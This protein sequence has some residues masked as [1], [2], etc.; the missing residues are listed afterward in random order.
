MQFSTICFSRLGFSKTN[1]FVFFPSIIINN[2]VFCLKS[3][4]LNVGKLE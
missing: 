3:F 4:K 2:A 1:W